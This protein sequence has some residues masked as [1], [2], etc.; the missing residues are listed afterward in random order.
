MI[1]A[2]CLV[3]AGEPSVAALERKARKLAAKGDYAGAYLAAEQAVARRP[4]DPALRALAATYQRQG[5]QGLRAFQSLKPAP[6]TKRRPALPEATAEDRRELA[7]PPMLQPDNVRRSFDL[8]ENPRALIAKVAEAYGI[9]VVFDS[10][11]PPSEP[12]RRLHIDNASWSEAIYALQL[13]ANAFYVPL[14][15]RMAL[16]AKETAVKRGEVEPNVSVAIPFP[17]TMSAQD[18]QDVANAV[19]Q[20]FGLTKV[21]IDSTQRAMVLRDR[22]SRVRPAVE[23]A[24]QLMNGPGEVYVDVD[25]VELDSNSNLGR[26]LQ[27]QT[28][29]PIVDFGS[30]ALFNNKPSIPAGF[31]NF[32]TWG[33]G[34]SYLGVGISSA[35]LMAT[36]A[37]SLGH[38]ITSTS[39]RSV[40]GQP[41]TIHIG[42]K[43]PIVQSAYVSPAAAATNGPSITALS[44][45]SA[46]AGSGAL[47]LVISGS[48]F[49]SAS[50]V[51]WIVNS[52]QSLLPS[53][54]VNSTQLTATV[55]ATL[56]ASAGSAGV[57]VQNGS[58]GL[59]ATSTFTIT[60]SVAEGVPAIGSL[61][62]SSAAAGGDAFTL[63]INGA[64]FAA[65][66]AVYWTENGTEILLSPTFVNSTQLTVPPARAAPRSPC[67]TA[68]SGRRPR[69][70]SPSHRHPTAA[71]R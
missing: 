22:L 64:N 34:A 52:T 62:P 45:S 65:D 63:I 58:G 35:Q 19:R 43:Y 59:T 24:R 28:S 8:R 32:Q 3:S 54:F 42:D 33:G 68:S 38:S 15:S 36:L 27:L 4:D 69:V 25:L 29:F 55:S 10:D 23:I 48:N 2:Q 56:L 31:T 71:L 12:P 9:R 40:S 17:D 67:K 5:L 1:L 60:S 53:S 49:T 30:K 6:E 37:S 61:M 41:A 14:N 20:A 51:Y 11:Y 47:A 46:A 13:V 21:A 66:S 39:L 7:P 26:G 50:V 57:E 18:L 16:F 70:L 44:P